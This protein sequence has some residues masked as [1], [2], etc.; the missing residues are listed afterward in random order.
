MKSSMP[1]SSR[2]SERWKPSGSVWRIVCSMTRG[3]AKPMSALGSAMFRSPSIAKDAVTPPV[4]GSVRTE[5]YGIRALGEARRA[6][7]RS[8]P[9]ASARGSPPACARRPSVETRIERLALG[10]RALG[11]ARDLLAD[12]RAHR[13][14]HEEELHRADHDRDALERRRS[15][16]TIASDGPDVVLGVAQPVAVLLAVAELQR[17]RRAQVRVELDVL[18]RRRRASAAARAPTAGSGTRTSGRS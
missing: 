16:T 1:C 4:V 7:R 12:D 9:S 8:W 11:R 5:M 17:V 2:N 3:P 6:P 15:P 18:A 13:A 14:A 10:E